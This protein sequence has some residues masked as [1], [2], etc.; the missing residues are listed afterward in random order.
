MVLLQ[1]LLSFWQISVSVAELKRDYTYPKRFELN[2]FN[3]LIDISQKIMR[4]K[5]KK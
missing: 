1:W 5:R 2:F 4:N 3:N